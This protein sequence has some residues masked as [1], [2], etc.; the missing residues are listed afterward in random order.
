MSKMISAGSSPKIIVDRIG[1]DISIVGW[2]G[3]EVLVKADD[4]EI[5]L[6][7]NGDNIRLSC[8]DDVSLR[9]PKASSTPAPAMAAWPP[10]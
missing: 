2:E 8:E 6:A 9:V 7:Q 4:D 1:G 5:T 3:A 10:K